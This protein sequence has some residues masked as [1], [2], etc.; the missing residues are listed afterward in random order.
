MGIYPTGPGLVEVLSPLGRE[1]LQHFATIL[2]LLQPVALER[3]HGASSLP[4]ANN[5]LSL[6]HPRLCLSKLSIPE[7]FRQPA[8]PWAGSR[9]SN[10]MMLSITRYAT[11]NAT[12]VP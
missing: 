9:L 2:T 4:I 8:P 3:L 6:P 11:G 7:A 1:E 12:V 10:A 5:R